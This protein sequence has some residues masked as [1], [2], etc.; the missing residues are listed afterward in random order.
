[1]PDLETIRALEPE[2][3]TEKR[4][5]V[6]WTPDLVNNEGDPKCEHEWVNG[7]DFIQTDKDGKALTE[8]ILPRICSKC[9]RKEYLFEHTTV[10]EDV[11]EQP[12]AILQAKVKAKI[13]LKE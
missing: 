6:I 4:F 7:R 5:S 3:T 2:V 10:L 11:V 9:D 8:R 13:K 12:Y 1:M